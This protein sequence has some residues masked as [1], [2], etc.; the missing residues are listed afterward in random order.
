M[1]KLTLFVI[2]M[3]V[4]SGCRASAPQT[5]L[6]IAF[7]KY[8]DP[9]ETE[10]S[11]IVKGENVSLFQVRRINDAVMYLPQPILEHLPSFTICKDEVHLQAEYDKKIFVVAGHCHQDGRVCL[12]DEE[13]ICDWVIWHE[14]LHAF[15]HHLILVGRSPFLEWEKIAGPVYLD[16]DP[17]NKLRPCK[18]DG[19]LS[20]YCRTNAWEDRAVFFTE[21]LNF[22]YRSSWGSLLTAN[23]LLKADPRYLQKLDALKAEGLFTDE[24]YDRLKPL[25]R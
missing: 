8:D 21:C 13:L 11:L 9:Q 16:D 2:A 19:L 22:L 20:D 18:P 3:L 6:S 15:D 12:K 5:Q 23:P 25:F 17:Q 7:H 10:Y 1:K 14:S 4:L 24:Q